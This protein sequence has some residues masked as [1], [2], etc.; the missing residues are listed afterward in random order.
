MSMI[1]QD[2]NTVQKLYAT[3]VQWNV[4]PTRSWKTSAEFCREFNH[5]D[6]GPQCGRLHSP[7]QSVIYTQLAGWYLPT[8]TS[9]RTRTHTRTHETRTMSHSARAR[10]HTHMHV[11]TQAHTQL[12]RIS[13]I[14]MTTQCLHS[15]I[16]IIYCLFVLTELQFY[17]YNVK[18][19]IAIHMN[20]L[21]N[22]MGK[23]EKCKMNITML[24]FILHRACILYRVFEQLLYRSP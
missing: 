23:N 9:S 18:V 1:W 2:T 12:T 3:A 22:M 10:V 5:D 21:H 6:E 14:Q 8:R 19:K 13:C 4:K 17:K 7:H 20:A 15:C 16:I 11:H 24:Q